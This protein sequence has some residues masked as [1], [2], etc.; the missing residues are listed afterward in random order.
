M[1]KFISILLAVV[2]VFTTMPLVTLAD[3]VYVDSDSFFDDISVVEETA[4]D[5]S[6]YNSILKLVE[7]LDEKEYTKE[8]IDAVKATVVD[9]AELT[10]QDDVDNAV[11]K[12]A[13]AYANLEK[14]SFEIVFTIIDSN[15]DEETQTYTYY[16]GEEALF[17]VDNGE[18]IYKWIISDDESDKKLNSTNEELSLVIKEAYSV[19]AFTDVEVDEY[20]LQQVK[21]L[22]FNGRIINVAYTNDISAVKMPEAPT[23]PFYY[24]TE[25]IKLN[26]FTY[27]AVYLSE[28]I[29][30]GSHHCFT[31]MVAKPTCENT[32]YVIFHCA[33]G[34]TYST[35]YTRP[36]GHNYEQGIKY[37][38]N[39]C[40]KLSPEFEDEEQQSSP[41]EPTQPREPTTVPEEQEKN[42]GFDEDGYNNVVVTP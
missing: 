11:R 33:C 26:D 17:K 36:I 9:K 32:G 8:S 2:M 34:E 28:T 14:N 31:T 39:G 1:K 18:N 5:Y 19:T 6:A 30:D 21:F 29:C 37:C 3:E 35:D 16:Y 23:I 13:F 12:I 4:P 24:F 10:T 42:Y 40:G 27:Q 25:W 22:S 38:V 20:E 15:G 41:V 7:A